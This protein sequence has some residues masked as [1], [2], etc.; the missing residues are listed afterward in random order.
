[1][2]HCQYGKLVGE[3]LVSYYDSYDAS[4]DPSNPNKN[5]IAYVNSE[6]AAALTG[7]L[8]EI[9]K[10]GESIGFSEM[11]RDRARQQYLYDNR[12]ANS[13]PVARPG[14]SNHEG[15]YAFDVP[16]RFQTTKVVS[17][18]KKWGF[19]KLKGDPP[20]F[21]WKNAPTGKSGSKTTL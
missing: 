15:G 11:F 13:N 2:F 14:T 5:N 19:V 12:G 17:I 3:H 1:M 21:G 7:A 9:D 4:S 8:G 10:A 16:E 18:L 20:H 6:I